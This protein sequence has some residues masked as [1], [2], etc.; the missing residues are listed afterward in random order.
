MADDNDDMLD[1]AEIEALLNSAAGA[2]PKPAA[3]APPASSAP[4]S[5]APAPGKRAAA[6]TATAAPAGE[7]LSH[8]DID[9]L[10]KAHSRG[11][12]AGN[13]EALL[14]SA[15][16]NL[17]AAL[18]PSG[19]PFADFVDPALGAKP[20]AFEEFDR[21]AGSEITTELGNLKD[22]ELN[23]RIELGRTELLIEEVLKLREG[24]VVA[25][26]KLAGD[27]VDIMV[28]GR[29]VARGEV[30]V[31]NDNFCVR[32]AEILAPALA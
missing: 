17:A 23:L 9:E 6:A 14:D 3:P 30:L 16:A 29:L 13:P 2:N 15:A 27:P 19:E 8:D 21:S 25:L 20:F 7:P 10:L 24:S 11:P 22:V 26:D 1:P 4:A 12:T 18:A 28:N 31:L 5:S 32:V